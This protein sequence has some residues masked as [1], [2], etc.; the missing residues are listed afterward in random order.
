MADRPI[1]G[2][3]GQRGPLAA[4]RAAL[5]GSMAL[6]AAV[7][8]TVLVLGGAGAA[9]YTLT[10]SGGPSGAPVVASR[11]TATPA[12]RAAILEQYRE[13]RKVEE[14]AELANPDKRRKL[15]TP[16][17][18]NPAYTTVMQGM[19]RWDRQGWK[20]W[21]QVESDPGKLTIRDG[22]ATLH[23]C[24]NYSRAGKAD[25]KTGEHLTVGKKRVH[26]ITRW[27]IVRG[28]WQIAKFQYPE[29]PCLR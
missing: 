23:A 2:V 17:L 29:T 4:A 20:S 28:K 7:V 21:G 26:E 11:P 19:A 14:K 27:E 5:S 12:A 9:A 13:Y 18:T 25:R 22:R 6:A 24:Q 10:Q 16:Y 8:A 1:S 3:G 15:L